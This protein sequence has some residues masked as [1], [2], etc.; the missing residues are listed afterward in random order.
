VSSVGNT[1]SYNTLDNNRNPKNGLRAE[2]R[3]DVAGLGGDVNFFRES[4][5]L[6][7][8]HDLGADVVGMSRLQAG[9]ITP[10]GGQS[11]PLANHFF[12]GPQL[13]RGFAPNGF[14]PR[15]TTAGTT[16]DNVGG[17]RYWATTAEL[18][19]PIP[20]MPSDIGLRV[21]VFADAGSMWGYRGVTSLPSLAQ[22]FQP[23][24][25]H[26]VRSSVGAGVIWDSPFGPLRVDYAMPLTR[27]SYDITQRL[28]FSPGF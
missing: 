14:G 22:S 4:G 12:G 15:D 5:D 28:R 25:S 21:A 23:A 8:Y 1:L 7:Y 17:T 26:T 16:M 3:Q 11:L 9:Y 20:F 19:S 27:A 13:V 10:W 6:R 2:L 24:D 18:Q